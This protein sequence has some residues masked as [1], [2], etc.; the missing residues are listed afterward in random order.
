MPATLTGI[1]RVEG[2]NPGGG[3]YRGMVAIMQ[4]GDQFSFKWWIGT[5]TFEGTGQLAGRMLVVNWGDKTPVV[6]TLGARDVLDGEWADGTATERL[7]LHGGRVARSRHAEGGHLPGGRAR[8][9]WHS[10]SGR[11]PHRQA[12]RRAIGSTGRSA[13]MSIKGKGTLDGNLFSV[14]WGSATPV[15]YALAAD[16]TLKGLWGAGMGE[17]TLTPER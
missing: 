13:R 4:T 2:N 14:D 16:G 12:G 15:V 11:G 7:T 3:R 8:C 5:Q 1:Y 9:E 17:E 6:Y 10:V